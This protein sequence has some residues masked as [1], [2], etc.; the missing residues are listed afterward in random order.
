M[1]SLEV[2]FNKNQPMTQLLPMLLCSS[3]ELCMTLSSKYKFCF[4]VKNFIIHWHALM[5]V[6]LLPSIQMTATTVA[7]DMWVIGSLSN[8]VT[9][10]WMQDTLMAILL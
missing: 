10:Q 2:M 5:V 6:A 9:G 1:L 8:S 3:A 4:C 7:V